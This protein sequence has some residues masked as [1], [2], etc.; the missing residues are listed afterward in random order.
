ME[1]KQ[2]I[3]NQAK[4]YLNQNDPVKAEK[5]YKKLWE[6]FQEEFNDWDG[7]FA[8]KS[9]K[10]KSQLNSNIDI[11]FAYEIAL[12]FSNNEKVNTSFGWLIY[13]NFIKNQADDFILQHEEQIESYVKIINQSDCS[14]NE[15]EF[16]CS[17]SR[18]IFKIIDIHKSKL[19][20]S[21][22]ILEYLEFLDH[23]RLSKKTFVINNL[24]NNKAQEMAS[25]YEK[26]FQIKQKHLFILE[27]YNECK[28]VCTYAL[29]NLDNFHHDNDLWFKRNYCRSQLKLGNFKQCEEGLLKLISSDGYGKWFIYY[30]LSELYFDQQ[31]NILAFKF[32]VDAGFY[33]DDYKMMPRLYLHQIK[34]LTEAKRFDEAKIIAHLLVSV[35]REENWPFGTNIK[36]VIN[37]YEINPENLDNANKYYIKVREFWLNEKMKDVNFK[38]GRISYVFSN[39]KKGKIKTNNN[40][41][42]LFR[43]KNLGNSNINLRN[44]KHQSVKF[45]G[46]ELSDNRKFAEYV[47]LSS[48]NVNDELVG[49]QLTGKIKKIMD[50][51]YFVSFRNDLPDGLLHK[52]NILEEKHD[53]FPNGLNVGDEIEVVIIKRDHKGLS[54]KLV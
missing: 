8:L 16:G 31:K 7:L 39:N 9:I 23:Q 11:N 34:L 24:N 14:T 40:D 4:D 1:T 15:S 25:D 20:S 10:K 46:V 49:Q 53:S 5:L 45:F 47:V 2:N 44:L 17:K 42:Y 43:K 36:E 27:M 35:Y 30:D 38:K 22:K 50:Y 33:G 51:G 32:A 54:L 48:S 18:I 19:H 26:Y 6:N 3:E 21:K 12:K 41:E 28:N 29:R 52:N 37:L 13:S